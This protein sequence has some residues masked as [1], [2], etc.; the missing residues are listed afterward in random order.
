M[1]FL[2]SQYELRIK[3]IFQQVLL[4]SAKAVFGN[5]GIFSE[6]VDSCINYNKGMKLLGLLYES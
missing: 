6:A 2:D 3:F 5:A 1:Y 4:E